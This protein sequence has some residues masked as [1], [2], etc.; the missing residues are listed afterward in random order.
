MYL[1]G[2]DGN[3]LHQCGTDY[4][5]HTNLSNIHKLREQAQNWKQHNKRLARVYLLHD[6]SQKAC[7]LSPKEFS[8]QVIDTCIR[9]A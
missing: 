4:T 6:I 5:L 9:L 2:I 8:K 7:E 1:I 3:G